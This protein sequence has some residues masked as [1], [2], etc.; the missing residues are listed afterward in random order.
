[1]PD[2]PLKLLLI[3]D[4][5]HDVELSVLTLERSGMLVEPV[6]AYDAPGV[7]RALTEQAFDLVL[8]DFLLPGFSG[9]Q[10][11]QIAQ[12]LAP[13]TPFIFLSG[14]FGEQHAVDMMRQ[15]AID[16]VLKQNLDMLPKAVNRAMAEVRERR[17]R[18]KAEAA[19][20]D[21]EVRAGLAVDAARLGT[22][23]LDPRTQRLVWDERCREL[24]GVGPEVE[25]D[26]D[27]FLARCHP[28]DRSLVLE[29]VEQAMSFDGDH[30]YH[31]EYRMPRADGS[32]RWLST[33]GRAFFEGSE[34]V[35]FIGVVQDI[36]EQR[37]ATESLQRMNERL[38]Q[39]VERRTR[40][41]DR[42]WD[43]SRDMLAILRF[44]LTPTEL[45]PA[46]EELLGWPRERLTRELLI[47]LV[48]PD[49]REA[50][51][52]E[53]LA[54]RRGKVSTR[55]IIRLRH[56][57]GD[58]RWF[59]WTL[60]PEGELMYASARDITAER[61]A[62]NELEAINQRLR[63]QIQER[64]RVE[65]TLQQMQRLE[66]VGQLTAGVAHDFNNLLTVV[67][68]S[69]RLL[70]R[71]LERESVSKAQARLQN[72]TDAGE[73]G[74]RLT[75]QLLAFSRRQRLEPEAV[76]L[77]EMVQGMGDLLQSTM[78]GRIRIETSTAEDLWHA[79]VD[80]TQIE[81]IM[82]NL[83]INARDA[84][85]EGGVL[86]LVTRNE[87][88]ALPAQRPEDPEPGDYVT[89]SVEDNGV[90]MDEEVLAKVFEP[91]FTTKAVGKGSGLGL[92]QVF[93][94]AKQSGGGVSI[95]TAP[96]QGTQVKVLLPAVVQPLREAREAVEAPPSSQAAP[97]RTILLVDDDASVRMVTGMLLGDMGYVVIEADSGDAALRALD[98]RVEMLV[99][100]YAMP[101]M[102]GAELAEAVRLRR[103]GLPILFITGYAEL[104]G[105]EMDDTLILQKPYREDELAA[106]L[107]QALHEDADSAA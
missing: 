93:G 72:I 25:L 76:N 56:V 22:W 49:D 34:C 40:E 85:P 55:F 58:Y 14:M 33:R 80:P 84:M 47:D 3:E 95:V 6:V 105:L 19:L 88:V 27:Y 100:D 7:E 90:G 11:L 30:L 66:A 26:L 101:G 44:D 12:R 54:I 106:K 74:A 99:T 86:R 1:M 98:G 28:Q 97:A 96:D 107:R 39:R 41:R 15:G 67:L 69:A 43:V 24:Y 5:S 68:T 46:W 73:R 75:A 18:Q 63:V 64:E 53:A 62:A 36:T 70:S 16:Y 94:F 83:A 78:G 13:T 60:V 8:S 45:N 87:R 10:A 32:E 57:D 81:M 29:R 103:P 17:R 77:N 51:L 50:T 20:R 92:A 52:R 42:V 82:L 104:G 61:Q 31:V 4:C 71:D 65:A 79:M 9:A 23:D 89:L 91:F 59:S 48:H 2:S 37:Q 21:V 35:R 102:T 38:G